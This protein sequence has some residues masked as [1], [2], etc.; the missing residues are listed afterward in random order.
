MTAEEKREEEAKPLD[1]KAILQICHDSIQSATQSYRVNEQQV[2]RGEEPTIPDFRTVVE[3]LVNQIIKLTTYIEDTLK[4]KALRYLDLVEQ[5]SDRY[6][7]AREHSDLLINLFSKL[8][9][10]CG[11]IADDENTDRDCEKCL[12]KNA[13]LMKVLQEIEVDQKEELEKCQSRSKS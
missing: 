6:Q 8:L 13:M 5:M 3:L 10:A 12:R 1:I 9:L 11:D 2:L 4:P 7:S